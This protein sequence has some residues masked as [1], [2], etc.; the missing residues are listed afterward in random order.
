MPTLRR[1]LSPPARGQISGVAEY[2]RG[3]FSQDDIGDQPPQVRLR[4]KDRFDGRRIELVRAKYARRAAI[5]IDLVVIVVKGVAMAKML[6]CTTTW[7][8]AAT[9]WS[10]HWAQCPPMR[11]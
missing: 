4:R 11:S 2:L 9:V 10:R 3:V 1:W 7:C 5:T 8:T 6:V